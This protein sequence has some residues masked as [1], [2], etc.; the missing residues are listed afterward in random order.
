[1]SEF[2]HVDSIEALNAFRV[3]LCKAAEQVGLGLEAADVEIQR[4]IHWLQ[5]EQ[6]MH[7]KGELR[8]R[9]ELAN[10]AALELKRKQ[11]EKT[12]SGHRYS[13]VDE[14]KALAVAKRRLEE[15]QQKLANV[16]RWARQL[17]EEAF[18]DFT[19]EERVLLRRFFLD[20]RDNLQ[21]VTG[22]E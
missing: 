3:M 21:R 19:L 17:E 7:W 18:A 10:R 14:K 20:I 1:M 15:A 5:Q 2:V 22:G 11:Q 12:P 6:R 13:C 8:K 4:T 9:N 16:Q